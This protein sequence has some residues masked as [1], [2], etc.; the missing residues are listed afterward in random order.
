MYC[1]YCYVYCYM[2][3]LYCPTYCTPVPQLDAEQLA[4]LRGAL[5]GWMTRPKRMLAPPGASELALE[6]ALRDFV[7]IQSVRPHLHA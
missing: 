2:Y 7:R 4:A 6:H 5:E 3:H 1:L